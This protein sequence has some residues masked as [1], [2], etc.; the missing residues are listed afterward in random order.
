MTMEF[1][2]EEKAKL[3]RKF[4]DFRFT[5][6]PSTCPAMLH[7]VTKAAVSL[8][9]GRRCQARTNTSSFTATCPSSRT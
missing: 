1:E 8:T 4:V 7:L 5:F 9:G 3:F 6:G 2:S